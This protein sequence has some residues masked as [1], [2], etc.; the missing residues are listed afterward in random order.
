M[1]GSA[2][3]CLSLL[4]LFAFAGGGAL[5]QQAFDWDGADLATVRLPPSAFPQLPDAVAR[6][7]SDR[8][9]TI[10]QLWY[11]KMP[12][13]A[14]SGEFQRPGQT[15]W[16]VLC[17]VERR[18]SILVFWNGS[19]AKVE[20]IPGTASTDRSWLQGVGRGKIG[21]SRAIAAVD[22]SYILERHA[23]YGGPTPPPIDHAGINH[24][25]AEKASSVLYWYHGNW[26]R[27]Q[28]AD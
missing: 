5:A 24:A 7:L 25:F 14:I 4:G 23:I 17:S 1:S 6:S 9:C 2:A 11:D 20:E 22:G 19:V 15:D 16:A 21:F 12:H 13:N 3:I 28:G 8:G 26:L 18:S 10:P 27:L